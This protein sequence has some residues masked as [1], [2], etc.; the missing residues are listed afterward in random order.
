MFSLFLLDTEPSKGCFS[1]QKNKKSEIDLIKLNSNLHIN[2][3]CPF[4]PTVQSK[5]KRLHVISPKRTI[6]LPDNSSIFTA[7]KA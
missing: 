4:I 5:M 2:I 7:A 6:R 3:T 1:L